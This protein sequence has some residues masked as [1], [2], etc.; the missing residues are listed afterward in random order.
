MKLL[1]ALYAAIGV[2]VTVVAIT[3]GVV[4]KTVTPTQQVTADLSYL[5]PQVTGLISNTGS[6][7]PITTL[8]NTKLGTRLSESE[9]QR[10]LPSNANA[11]WSNYTRPEEYPNMVTL[12]SQWIILLPADAAG[13]AILK[14]SCDFDSN[15]L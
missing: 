10:P 5:F 1:Y 15:L 4:N 11:T 3:V 8:K 2:G 9:V 14:S 12:P 6:A 13:N 7:Q